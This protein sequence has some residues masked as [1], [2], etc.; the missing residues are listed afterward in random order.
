MEKYGV[1]RQATEDDITRRRKDARILTHTHNINTY[2]LA[3]ATM[4][5]ERASILRY[6]YIVCLVGNQKCRRVNCANIIFA[7]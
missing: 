1:T 3:S 7:V 6:M 5:H 2:G 4:V